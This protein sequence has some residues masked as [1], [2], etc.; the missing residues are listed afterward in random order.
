VSDTREG[1]SREARSWSTAD[2]VLVALLAIVGTF[3]LLQLLW[4]KYGRDQGIY[5]V[6]ADTVLRGGMPYRDAWDFK[7]PG[8]FFVYIIA[9]LLFG[10]NEW[11]IRAVEVMAFLSL[12][13]IM[14]TLARRF[15]GDARVGW[16][17][18]VLS[19]WIQSQLEFW[20][21]AQPESFGGVLALAGLAISTHPSSLDNRGQRWKPWVLGLLAGFFFGAS[22]LMKPHLFGVALVAATHAVWTLRKSGHGWRRQ[23]AAFSTIGFGSVIPIVL[24]I[25]WFAARGALSDLHHTLFVFAPCYA[26]TTWNQQQFFHYLYAAAYRVTGGYSA[27]VG[28]GMVLTAVWGKRTTREREGLLLIA[29]AALP[30]V[31]GIAIQSKFFAYHF[32]ATFPFCALFASVGIWRTWQYA[33]RWPWLGPTLFALGTVAAADART[34]TVD[35][36]DSFLQRSFK[37]TRAML[38]ESKEQRDRIDGELYTVADVHYGANRRVAQWLEQHTSSQD[39]V[40]IWGFEPHIYAASAR[41]PASR[42]IYN[43]PQRVAWENQWARDVLMEDLRKDPPKVIVVEH[44]DIFPIVTGNHSDSAHAL[45]SFPE[46]EQ[47]METYRKQ[48]RI[49]DFD[50]FVREINATP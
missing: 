34:A 46:L 38:F 40:F 20:H 11:S 22:G 25:V 45:A 36:S 50:I 29:L 24:C 21:T 37:R 9:H 6:V 5:A 39:T 49:Q 48:D 2:R 16:V 41:R 44:G 12:V 35:L 47:W 28:I 8:I 18:A 3:C 26:S 23:L 15:F 7:P 13:P 30:Q 4:M 10:S 43:V 1:A 19:I 17:A 14:G 32:G 31:L 27:I 33:Q 42:F